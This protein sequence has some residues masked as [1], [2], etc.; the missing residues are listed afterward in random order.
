MKTLLSFS[1]IFLL[2]ATLPACA[3]SSSPSPVKKI[4]EGNFQPL[5]D[6]KK[7]KEKRYQSILVGIVTP[8]ETT[9]IPFGTLTDKGAAPNA[10]TVFEI[11]SI[12]KGFLGLTLAHES[13]NGSLDLDAPY[14]KKTLITW[15]NLAQHTAGFPRMP[16]NHKPANPMQPYEDY[17]QAKLESFLQG[18]RFKTKPGVKSEYSNLSSGLA[19][20]RLSEMHKKSLEQVLEPIY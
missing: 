11:G 13:L 3:T 17:D 19:G 16:D 10:S 4:V 2:L 18:F 20:F 6:L 8:F 12:T 7:P 5:V 15:R 9:I 14:T 1:S